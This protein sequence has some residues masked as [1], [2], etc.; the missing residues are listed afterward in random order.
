MEKFKPLITGINGQDVSYLAE[1]ALSKGYEVHVAFW[2]EAIFGK[3]RRVL[4]DLKLHG[5]SVDN[6]LTTL[7]LPT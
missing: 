2:L 7:A 5:G 4:D 3:N 6:H 1:L